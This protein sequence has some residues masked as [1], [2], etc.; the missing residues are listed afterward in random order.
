V[1]SEK[2]IENPVTGVRIVFRRTTDDTNGRAVI[3]E[4]FVPPNGRGFATHVHPR[5]EERVDVLHGAVGVRVGR[6]RSSVGP[7]GRITVPAG[8]RHGFWNAGEDVAHVVCELRPALRF[9]SLLEATFA[10]AAGGEA[11]G[12]AEP[13]LLR[14]AVIASAHLDTVRAAF[15][16]AW[17]QRVALG[18]AVRAGRMLG[19]THLSPPAP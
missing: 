12:R 13:R 16:P 19:H 1:S 15:L 9:D 2:V 11:D 14:R 4:M 18:V 17:M 10:L 8:V 7:G 5:Q 3:F 6:R